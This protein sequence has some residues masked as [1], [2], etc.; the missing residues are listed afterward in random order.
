MHHEA[1]NYQAKLKVKTHVC[2]IEKENEDF[3]TTI[4][5]FFIYIIFLFYQRF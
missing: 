3:I 1:R 5:K 4:Q 2:E